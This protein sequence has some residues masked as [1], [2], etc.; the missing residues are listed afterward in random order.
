MI[1]K[2]NTLIGKEKLVENIKILLY[3]EDSNIFDLIEFEDDNI[4]QE[5][6]LFAYFNSEKRDI[7]IL[8]TILYGYMNFE[9]Q[10]KGV[11][12]ESDENGRIYLPNL[13]WL[14]T[15]KIIQKFKL[16]KN[17]HNKIRLFYNAVESE[18]QLEPIIKIKNTN[19]EYLKYSI[20]LLK[21][22]YYDVD[23]NLINVEI[24]KIASKHLQNVTK[25]L[26]LIKQF[27]PKHFDLI[28]LI[29]KKIAVFNVDTYLRNSF[30][31]LSA[32]GISFS[33]AYQK[34]YNEVFFIDDIAHQTGH[35]IFNALIYD[36]PNFIK[37][38]PTTILENLELGDNSTETRSIR[39][40]FHALY[41][42]HTTFTCLNACLD[43]EVFDTKRTHEALGRLYFYIGKCYKDLMLV[44]TANINNT[45]VDIKDL[46]TEN[47]LD[48]Y[49]EI[50]NKFN[51]IREKWGNIL[52]SLNMSNQP[53]NFTYSKFV[54]LNP[55][56]ENNN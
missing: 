12:I 37:I 13:G 18:Y 32:H 40:V 54:E 1:K 3:K 33:N 26:S 39:I 9:A 44:E 24:E 25:A 28:N 17:E 36:L 34:E 49:F 29:T 55:L 35:V 56:D 45:P 53:Y 11:I 6:L 16:F 23:N 46:F 14:I 48:I 51:F 15:G 31:T 38:D 7:S 43:A 52:S 22:C 21:Q 30:A 2:K 50:K 27:T 19:I 5:P 47:G 10:R 42:Y 20:P 8:H 4:Y 41:T